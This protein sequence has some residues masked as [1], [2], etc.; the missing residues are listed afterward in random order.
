MPRYGRWRLW[1]RI[2]L[3]PVCGWGLVVGCQALSNR[4]SKWKML[5][6]DAVEDPVRA[7]GGDAIVFAPRERDHPPPG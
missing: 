2:L 7:V 3:L 4:L 1:G 5:G 6:N